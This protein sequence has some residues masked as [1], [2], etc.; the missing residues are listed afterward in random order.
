MRPNFCDTL[1]TKPARDIKAT[2]RSVSGRYAFRGESSVGFESTLERD[3]IMR[4]EFRVDVQDI[5]S[6]PVTLSYSMADSREN[7]YTPDFLV[8]FRLTDEPYPL[9]PRPLLVEVKPYEVWTEELDE[10]RPKWRAA[11]RYARERDCDFRVHDESR[12]RDRALDNIRR[13]GRYRVMDTP[14]DENRWILDQVRT[15]G[16]TPIHYLIARHFPG[17][18]RGVATARIW[19]LIATRR[20]DCNVNEPLDEFTEVWATSND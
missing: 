18:D 8:Y 15:M 1:P 14:E 10:L 6:Q 7:K 20:L 11:I 12:I 5:V 16:G 13:L 2:W 3:F 17:E 19:H 4:T 9:Y